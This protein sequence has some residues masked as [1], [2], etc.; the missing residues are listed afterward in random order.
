LLPEIAT[1]DTA[2]GPHQ[3]P[4]YSVLNLRI[5]VAHG[6]L[7]ASVFV[8]NATNADPVLGYYHFGLGDPTF[9]A[10]MIRPLTTGITVRYAF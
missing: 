7:D 1:Y 10:T 8:D 6:G 2:L 4:A 5:G 3:D 9:Q